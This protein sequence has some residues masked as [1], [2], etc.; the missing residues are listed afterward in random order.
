MVQFGQ[1]PRRRYQSGLRGNSFHVGQYPQQVA[2][3]YLA[4][5]FI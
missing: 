2:T 3:Q 5:V 1:R 4:D